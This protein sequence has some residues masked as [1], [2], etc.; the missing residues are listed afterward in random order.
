M[1]L[2]SMFDMGKSYVSNNSGVK[3]QRKMRCHDGSHSLLKSLWCVVVC[4]VT[5]VSYFFVDKNFGTIQEEFSE[6]NI[7]YIHDI[8]EFVRI[9]GC[10]PSS[11]F[12]IS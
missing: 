8:D 9:V 10:I 11:Q 6:L 4:F 2:G 1:Y 7:I 3:N 12:T 5:V